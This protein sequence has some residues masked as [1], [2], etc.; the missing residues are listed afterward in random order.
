MHV[1]CGKIRTYRLTTIPPVTHT[2]TTQKDHC[3][4]LGMH[5]PEHFSEHL[6]KP[7]YSNLMLTH[8]YLPETQHM[9]PI[10]RTERS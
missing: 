1:Y 7:E 9:E 8:T 4:H 5:T 2:L 3:Q 10:S 6:R